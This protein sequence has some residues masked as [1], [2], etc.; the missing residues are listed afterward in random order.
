MPDQV[1]C[2][3][4][5]A[6][7][8]IGHELAI[9]QSTGAS[10]KKRRPYLLN[11]RGVIRQQ[12]AFSLNPNATGVLAK[13]LLLLKSAAC[14]SQIRAIQS[15]INASQHLL[16]P[17]FSCLCALPAV[18]PATTLWRWNSRD[19]QSDGQG[20]ILQTAME[21]LPSLVSLQESYM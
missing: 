5:R 12:S 13:S 1:S 17:G 7:C 4:R 8:I 16:L 21:N 20:I 19:T 14:T 11:P 2:P 3:Q 15:F 10:F 18:A 6:V 9:Q